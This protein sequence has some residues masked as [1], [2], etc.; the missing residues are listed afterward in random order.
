M[1]TRVLS[2]TRP[3]GKL[4]LGHLL[5]TLENYKKL[6]GQ[7]AY[8]MIADWHAL[9]TE[10]ESHTEIAA[11]VL[12]VMIDYLAS[13]LDPT[14]CT[15]FVQ[16]EVHEHAEMAL[17]LSMITP[18]GWLERNPTY[19]DQLKELQNKDLHTH[20]FLGYP[21]LQ[22]ADILLYKAEKVPVGEDQLPHL[23]L[24]REIAR[25]FHHLYGKEIFT[26]PEAILT[27]I[28]RVPGLDGRKMSKS[29]NNCIYISDSAEEV[30]KKVKTM[31]TD[32]ARKRREDKG[33]PEVCPVYALHKI[34]NPENVETVAFECRTAQRGCVECKMEMAIK[35][36]EFLAPVRKRH[37]EWSGRKDDIRV[38]LDLGRDKA[39]KVARATLDETMKAVGMR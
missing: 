30:T 4:H 25:R 17:L 23:E 31:V 11:N 35:L 5:G 21:V 22:A 14:K 3:T 1:S 20:G 6:E 10:Y 34:V 9:T 38:I 32:P 26:E 36:N 28:P 7:D 18:L 16:S 19:K 13:G 2:G 24:T 8:F 39:Q 15:I 29:Y 33:H 37:E 27:Q 12:A